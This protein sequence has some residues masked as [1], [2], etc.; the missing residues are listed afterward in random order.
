L[1]GDCCGSHHVQGQK[2]KSAPEGAF[3]L[4]IWRRSP[5]WAQTI[6]EKHMIGVV[7]L[8]PTVA[9]AY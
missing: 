1:A 9:S 2:Q 4:S 8:D 5:T 3:L 7:I 6:S